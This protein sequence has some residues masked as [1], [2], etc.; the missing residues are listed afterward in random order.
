MGQCT[1]GIGRLATTSSDS[2]YIF[3]QKCGRKRL[4]LSFKLK[5]VHLLFLLG[6]SAAWIPRLGGRDLP[7]EVRPVR[8]EA[9]HL[10]G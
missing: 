8:L 10:R 4:V 3:H 1:S 5:E 7:D 6:S 2:R 9:D